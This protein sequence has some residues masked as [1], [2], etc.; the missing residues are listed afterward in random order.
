MHEFA[1]S[2]SLLE[3]DQGLRGLDSVGAADLEGQ[4]SEL[5]QV[6]VFGDDDFVPSSQG[7]VCSLDAFE[8]FETFWNCFR[9]TGLGRY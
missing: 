4:L 8:S 2:Q 3:S 6:H 5:F 9:F 1:M 7:C